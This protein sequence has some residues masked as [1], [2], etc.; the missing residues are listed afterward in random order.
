MNPPDDQRRRIRP[1]ILPGSRDAPMTA[2]ARG[3]SIGRSDAAVACRRRRSAEATPSA[4]GVS[5]NWTSTVPAADRDRISN[6]ESRK[7]SRIAAFSASVVA[8]NRWKPWSA[9]RAASRSSSSVPIPLP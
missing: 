7:T 4:D 9:A 5:D 1:P 8:W 6:P 3:A 2:T